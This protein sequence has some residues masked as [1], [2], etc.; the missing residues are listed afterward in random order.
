MRLLAETGIV[1]MS[2]FTTWLVLHWQ[3]AK[4]L[5]QSGRDALAVAFGLV[6]QLFLLALLMEGFSLDTFGLPYYWIAIGLLAS[7]GRLRENTPAG[8]AN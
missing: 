3:R 5:E 8:P 2:A 7:V 6:G 1:G 4:Q